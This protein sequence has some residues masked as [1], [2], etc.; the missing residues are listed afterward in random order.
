MLGAQFNSRTDQMVQGNQAAIQVEYCPLRVEGRKPQR[1]T[2]RCSLNILSTVPF[3]VPH[4]LSPDY[5]QTAWTMP[6]F[7]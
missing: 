6:P 7:L 5:Y 1:S 4:Q 3:A 2:T